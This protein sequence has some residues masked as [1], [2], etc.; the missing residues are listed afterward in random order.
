MA[1]GA[2]F[3]SGGASSHRGFGVA[4][5]HPQFQ[6]PSRNAPL[7]RTVT[8]PASSTDQRHRC[9]EHGFGTPGNDREREPRRR[10]KL[11]HTGLRLQEHKKLGAC[12]TPMNMLLIGW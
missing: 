1:T 3:P 12:R 11:R 2:G 6:L 5:G 4:L 8:Q 10:A 9:A 7:K